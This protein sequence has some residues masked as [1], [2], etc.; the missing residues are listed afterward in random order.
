MAGKKTITAPGH[1]HSACAL[2]IS[3]T[4]LVSHWTACCLSAVSVQG[5]LPL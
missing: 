1:F 2:G 4:L 3:Q 5:R